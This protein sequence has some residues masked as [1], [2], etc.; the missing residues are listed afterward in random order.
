MQWFCAMNRESNNFQS[1]SLLWSPCPIAL[2]ILLQ[3]IMLVM[4]QGPASL[5]QDKSTSMLIQ[6][7]CTLGQ[8]TMAFGWD[9]Q[10]RHQ[11]FM[12]SSFNVF[13]FASGLR[14]MDGL[15][16]FYK[17]E[18]TMKLFS[19]LSC[20]VRLQTDINWNN[21]P[22][23][24]AALGSV[25]QNKVPVL[26]THCALLEQSPMRGF[27]PLEGTGH[28]QGIIPRATVYAEAANP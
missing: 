22:C 24:G 1:Q 2:A 21:S 12:Q 25:F 14:L 3:I 27:F 13:W 9:Q 5:L 7:I 6:V 10:C 19:F 15:Y 8:E 18:K 17:K 28:P 11:N 26:L 20:V 23:S 4:L 16:L